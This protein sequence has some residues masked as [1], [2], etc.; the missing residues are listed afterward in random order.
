MSVKSTSILKKLWAKFFFFYLISRAK[1]IKRNQRHGFVDERQLKTI[2][3]KKKIISPK[4]PCTFLLAKSDA[5]FQIFFQR[6]SKFWWRQF[7]SIVNVWHSITFNLFG[8]LTELKNAE[9]KTN[10][11][12]YSLIYLFFNWT[13][14]IK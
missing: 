5:F 14:V 12:L 1:Q 3:K 11:F 13:K 9:K 7:F 6:K 2:M 8:Y 10:T 4:L